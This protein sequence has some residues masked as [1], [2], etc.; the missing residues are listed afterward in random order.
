MNIFDGAYKLPPKDLIETK[1]KNTRDNF[2]YYYS[3]FF[4]NIIN[5]SK[6]ENFTVY[7]GIM[8]EY[9]NSAIT[10]ENKI[11]GEYSPELFYKLNKLLI[12][13]IKEYEN[14]SYTLK[15]LK[16]IHFYQCME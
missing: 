4:N 16:Q 9:D 3:L 5:D 11:Y 1:I 7:K 10:K 15:F 12:K 14:D 6:I 8:L 2:T 13:S